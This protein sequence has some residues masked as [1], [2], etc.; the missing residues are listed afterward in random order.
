MSQYKGGALLV[1]PFFYI[2]SRELNFRGFLC[3]RLKKEEAEKYG[4]FIVD[5]QSH[6]DLFDNKFKK[7]FIEYYSFPRGRVAYDCIR[8]RHVVYIDKCLQGKVTEIADLFEISD[9]I[10][11]FDEHYVCSKCMGNI[12]DE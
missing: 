6:A 4:D 12:W 1:G 3:H 11:G 10:V 2:V 5:P 9:Y 8:C 7:S